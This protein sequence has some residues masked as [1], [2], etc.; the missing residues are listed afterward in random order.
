MPLI[1]LTEN[2]KNEYD[3]LF[4]TCLITAGK[5]PL[6]EKIADK[7]LVNK[8]RYDIVASGLGIPWFFIGVIH[9]MEASLNFNTHL[10]NGDPLTARTIHVPSGR[11]KEGNPPFSW[12]QSAEDSLKLMKL[13]KW[14]D[15]S[16]PAILYK[17]EEYN[18]F[19]YRTKH[20]SVL[21]PYLWSFSGHYSKGK[22]IADGTWSDTA[23]S[24]QCG[25]AVILRR[26]AERGDITLGKGIPSVSETEGGNVFLQYSNK[27]IPY[28]EELQF[29]LNKF[30][31]VFVKVDGWPGEKTSDAFKKV[32][33]IYLPGDPRG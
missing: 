22:Y 4:N 15:W 19:G 21:S 14:T 18:G 7:I 5:L 1:S 25:A 6:V 10:H 2:L 24:G 11:P 29:F 33:G 27:K 26:M 12:E 32:F 30:P 3:N 28:A 13:D 23:V 20:P 17:I 16:L 9:N 31:G 8:T